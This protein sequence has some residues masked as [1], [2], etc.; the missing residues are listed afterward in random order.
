MAL[1]VT[2]DASAPKERCCLC[3]TPTIAWYNTK[4]VALCFTCAKTAK[5]SYLPSK[6]EWLRRERELAVVE[7]TL[8]KQFLPKGVKLGGILTLE[9]L[10]K[11][12]I[13]VKS[14][15]VANGFTHGTISELQSMV[16]NGLAELQELLKNEL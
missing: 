6:A 7:Y 15:V 13:G 14:S 1:K 2:H 11:I 9:V 16:E 4:E 3:R 5:H 10:A 8:C 12:V